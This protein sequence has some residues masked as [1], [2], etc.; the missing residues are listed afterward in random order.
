MAAVTTAAA[1]APRQT[2]ADRVL[3]NPDAYGRLSAVGRQV[4]TTHEATHVATRADTRP[5]TPLWLSEGA[6]DWTGYLD[7]GRTPRQIAPELAR[8]VAAGQLPSALPADA[9]FAAGAPGLARTYELA[10]LACDLIARRYGQSKLVAFYRAVGAA[11]EGAGREQ[12]LDRVLRAELGTGL[13]EF[14]GDWVAEA[15]RLFAA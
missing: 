8:A 11:G 6:A 7:T 1:G 15:H 2:P 10:W 4:V 5:W 13:G 14:T 12:Q 9:D 3:V